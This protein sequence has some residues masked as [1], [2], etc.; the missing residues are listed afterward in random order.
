MAMALCPEKQ[1]KAQ[2]EIDALLG[3]DHLPTVADRDKLPYVSAIIKETM[4]WH[5]TLPL[6]LARQTD[7]DDVYEGYFIPRGTMVMPN[8]WF[9]AYDADARYDPE[10]F[11]PE[12]FL[13]E[14][15]PTPD[16]ASWVFGFGR[17]VCP[18]RF[19]AENSVFVI[20]ANILAAFDISLPTE[21][22]LSP[23]FTLDLV[24][25]PE[26][27]ECQITPRSDAMARLVESRAI[28][29]NI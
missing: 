19:L 15:V 23:K 5:P 28:Q 16:P 7:K 1:W 12:R 6:S 17:R 27:Y 9:I 20:V 2:E 3:G 13:D 29:C 4:R 18:G 21:G 26:P 8:V 11:I 10:E 24:S 14:D 22:N 25:Y